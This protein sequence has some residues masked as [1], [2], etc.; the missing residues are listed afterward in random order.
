MTRNCQIDRFT[1]GSRSARMLLGLGPAV[2]MMLMVKCVTGFVG[3][4]V[5]LGPAGSSPAGRKEVHPDRSWP[6]GRMEPSLYH[7]AG[8]GPLHGPAL[9][10]IA[11]NRLPALTNLSRTTS[12]L[13][14]A[15]RH[16]R[17]GRYRKWRHV[18]S[19]SPA[20]PVAL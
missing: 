10:R 20:P 16:T 18:P 5:V 17:L 9:I 11:S 12:L 8:P 4:E 15:P 14:P 2:D 7:T 6:A 13:G 1:V 19:R 3:P